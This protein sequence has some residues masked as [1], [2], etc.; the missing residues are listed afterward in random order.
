M[1]TFL[2]AMALCLTL[3]VAFKS[4]SMKNPEAGLHYIVREP[5]IK[6]AKPPVIILLHGVGS[7]EKDLFSFANHLPDHFLVISARAPYTIGR[8]SYSWFEIDLSTGKAIINKVQA[9]KSRNTL[10]Q[11]IG[12]LKEQYPFDEKQVYLCGFSQGAIMA[13]SVGLTRSDIVK[14]IAIMSGGLL[15][16]VKPSI[17]PTEQLKRL[18]IF[19]SHGIN[20]NTLSINYARNAVAYLK[21]IKINPT[22]KEYVAGHELNNEMFND[23]LRW[24]NDK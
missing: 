11:F 15:E 9:E 22:Y 19:I 17:V 4:M 18:R 2:I 16:E 3:I 7:N 13:F 8:D 14:G 10:I 21:E 23:L 5:K 1:K 24:L 12:Q 6:S 20:D